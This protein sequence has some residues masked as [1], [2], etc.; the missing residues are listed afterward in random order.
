MSAQPAQPK[1]VERVYIRLVDSHNQELLL[2]L[3]QVIDK[4][5]GMTDVILVL[6]PASNKQ[7]IKL[8]TGISKDEATI[9]KL[10]QIIGAE[11][12]KVQ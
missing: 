1:K 3:K 11:N 8:P 4:A 9:E 5:T 10:R 6:G 12:V 7:I 2:A